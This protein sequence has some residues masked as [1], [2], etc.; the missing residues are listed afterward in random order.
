MRDSDTSAG[1]VN[2]TKMSA[3]RQQH[4]ASA[5]ASASSPFFRLPLDIQHQVC[6]LFCR[7]CR[8][9]GRPSSPSV[10][11]FAAADSCFATLKA[12]SETCRALK[13]LAQPILYHY[14]TVKTYTPFFKTVTTRPALA[15]SVK[16][17][18]RMYESDWYSLEGPLQHSKE[19]IPYLIEL[20]RSLGLNEDADEVDEAEEPWAKDDADFSRCFKY[21]HECAE[22]DALGVTIDV[23]HQSYY[24]LLTALHFAILPKL[25]FV[26]IDLYDGTWPLQQSAFI[27]GQLALS[28]PYLPKV[29]AVKPDH[30]AQLN[31]VVFRNSY[32]NRQE[33]L[34]LE[35]IAFLLPIITHIRVVFFQALRGQIYQDDAQ[36]QSCSPRVEPSWPALT[37]LE[38]VYFDPCVRLNSPA[39]LVAISNMLRCCPRLKKLVYRHKYSDQFNPTLFFPTE[40]L[41]AILV[42]KHTLLHLE[43]YCSYAKVPSFPSESLMDFRLKELTLL[44]TLVIDEELFCQHWLSDDSNAT[45]NASF[46]TCLISILPETVSWLT[47]RLHDKLKAVPDIAQLGKEIAL[48]HHNSQLSFLQVYV[49]HDVAG[50]ADPYNLNNDPDAFDST[51]FLY[52]VEPETCEEALQVEVESIRPTIVQAFSGTNVMVKVAYRYEAVISSKQAPFRH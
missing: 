28:Y 20:A 39:P 15:A 14:P 5:P 12:L 27:N 16:V 51:Y 43:M 17:L 4:K 3:L 37:C 2:S 18:A 42:A 19:D 21:L 52:A 10:L 1:K 26:M 30:F 35:R 41:D 8:G 46:D 31:T 38:E 7:H 45:V 34:G 11:L 13:E 44:T 29:V 50:L 32:H 33:S 24:S 40:L 25:E 22:E 49:I 6:F 47:V 9:Q 36:T 23:A 48:G